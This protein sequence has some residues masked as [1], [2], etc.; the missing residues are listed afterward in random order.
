L[1]RL[2]YFVV[3][4]L[5][6]GA[7]V[8]GWAFKDHPQMRALLD[9][10][11]GKSEHAVGDGGDLKSKLESAALGMLDR[12][13]PRQAGAFKVKIA[14]IKLDPKLFKAGHTVDI[15]TRVR[16]LD[17]QGKETIIWQSKSYGENLAVVGKD[18]L[19]VTFV[20]RPFEM[21][22]SPGDRVFVD[23]WDR[24]GGLFDRMELKMALPEPG[25]FPLASGIHALEVVGHGGSSLDSD[26]SW[27]V[28]QTKRARDSR[29]QQSGDS[30]PDD[31]REIAERPIVIK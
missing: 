29:N 16:K 12:E 4:V 25:V 5:T 18:D 22:W 7:G 28:F 10:V 20:S 6:G 17:A 3:M 9:L 31:P 19:T 13:N 1:R 27:I 30:R 15:Q 23:V 2:V 26:Q 14:E 21:E 8:G 11:L 24:N